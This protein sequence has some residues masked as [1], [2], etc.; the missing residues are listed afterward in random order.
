MKPVKNSILQEPPISPI[1]ASFYSA[2]L[3]DIFG[4]PTNLIEILE[5]H[6]YNHPTHVSILMYVDDG[7]LIVSS[8]SLDINNY[9]LAK[10]YQLVDQ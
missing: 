9:I 3:L 7:K 8:H 10:A 5:N 4:T 1:L 2:G 6:T